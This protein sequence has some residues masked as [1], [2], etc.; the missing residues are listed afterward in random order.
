MRMLPILGI[1]K[2]LA[3]VAGVGVVERPPA[4]GDP[5][6]TIL[7]TSGLP[8][9]PGL[10]WSGQSNPSGARQAGVGPAVAGAVHA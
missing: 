7:R 2:T 10:V 9:A 5:L 8:N 1:Q 4:A 3:S 6:A